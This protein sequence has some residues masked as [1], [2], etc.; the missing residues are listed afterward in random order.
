MQASEISSIQILSS[1][2]RDVQKLDAS[3]ETMPMLQREVGCDPMIPTH[4]S[5][6]T[7]SS[8]EERLSAR[9]VYISNQTVEMILEAIEDAGR[10]NKYFEK[11]EAFR[12]NERL[13]LVLVKRI[14]LESVS[15]CFQSKKRFQNF[16]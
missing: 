6:Q 5:T 1:W 8:A 16:R 15:F 13:Q 11:L 9:G 7:E 2:N 10:L 12:K 14:I 4:A 3:I